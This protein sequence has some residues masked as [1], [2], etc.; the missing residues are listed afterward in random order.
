MAAVRQAS[1][2]FDSS[3]QSMQSTA[4]KTGSSVEASMEKVGIRSHRE[5]NRQIQS[6]ERAYESL[7]ASG[8][9]TQRELAQ[10]SLAM[11]DKIRDLRRETSGWTQSLDAMKFELAAAGAAIFGTVRVLG[12]AARASAEF[13]TSLAEITTLNFSGSIAELRQEIEQLSLTYGGDV[14]TNSQAAYDIISAG[15][16]EATEA[17]EQ[18]TAANRLAVG[19]KTDVAT[20]ASGVSSILAAYGDAARGA[21]NVT[22]ALFI[23]MRGGKTTIGELSASIGDVSGLAASAGVGLEAMLASA[24]TLTITAGS[25][26][27]AIT[28]LRGIISAIIKPTAE[29]VKEADRLGI[30]FD[31]AAIR[32]QGFAAWLEE[33]R[34]KTGGSEAALGKLFG[35][36]EGLNGILQLT[37][38]SAGT[39][40]DIL[41]Q[42][43]NKAGATEA[44]VG[45]MFDT[46]AQRAARFEQSMASVQRSLGDAVT[47]FSPVLDGLSDLLAGFNALDPGMRAVIAGAGGISVA[48]LA[49]LPAV[50]SVTR[51][52]TVLRTGV[53]AATGS[54]ALHTKALQGN[55]SA[56]LGSVGAFRALAVAMRAVPWL[57]VIGAIT[58]T[59]TATRNLIAAKR[60][61]ADAEADLAVGS[62]RLAERLAQ[63]AEQTGMVFDS[64][65]D[66]RAAVEA[67]TIVFD[68]A[69][70]RWQAA[71]DAQGDLSEN[72]AETTEAVERQTSA[73]EDHY[74]GL[75]DSARAAREL[76]E[77]LRAIDPAAAGAADSVDALLAG[78]DLADQAD[79]RTLR[80]ALADLGEASDDVATIVEDRLVARIREADGQTLAGL[81]RE[82]RAVEASGNDA[83]A[84]LEN[85]ASEALAESF[86]RL[87]LTMEAELGR[88]SPAAQEAIS[89]VD[90]IIAG[91]EGMG[92]EAE[93]QSD[94]IESAL[95]KAFASADS[96]AALAELEAR[97]QSAADTGS[98]S[99]A[100]FGRLRESLA[101]LRGEAAAAAPEVAD[102]ADAQRDAADGADRYSKAVET[103]AT[104]TRR[105]RSATLDHAAALRDHGFS[106]RDAAEGADFYGATLARIRRET[107]E[108]IR[109]LAA[110]TRWWN[111]SA[112]AARE[113]TERFIR[114]ERALDDL[115]EQTGS[116]TRRTADLELQLLELNGTEAEIAAARAERER[117]QIE[118]EIERNRLLAERARLAGNDEEAQ[119]FRRENDELRKQLDLLRQIAEAE[120]RN[121]EASSAA[122]PDG[123]DRQSDRTTTIRLE[124]GGPSVDVPVEIER[125]I[126]E[127]IEEAIRRSG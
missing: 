16:S 106:A 40:N 59:V 17:I 5:I 115:D 2:T 39:F 72:A 65:D 81:I 3:L 77:G 54:T 24:S 60:E 11:R 48:L 89:A 10:A 58:D 103:A 45:Q 9:L 123:R 8:K 27:K 52:I 98:L 102:V 88:V 62:E 80:L 113:A 94:V 93:Q 46:P 117:Q 55:T 124:G 78:L 38:E 50:A 71:A 121:R 79:L 47:A 73:L 92:L 68:E 96:A 70:G 28:Q 67:G 33:L 37:G 4:A 6:I 35:N 25:T 125:D 126:L 82:I 42:M 74:A 95:A 120:R 75:L 85:M 23:A 31:T 99:A 20:A 14:V 105:S 66:L 12:Q 83:G 57:L 104:E 63:V 29:A 32:S 84:A 107:G 56:A 76:I 108:G 34:E 19:G 18:L 22:D 90:G 26:A 7:A 100:A 122:D 118:L 1:N 116:T 30:Q 13:Q 44:A 86:R 114:L 41:D 49:L 119:T 87:G 111:N 127:L 110:Y 91:I 112:E 21:T 36:I 109:G 43:E 69:A 15:A 64:V 97:M 61:L 53:I 51:A 101:E